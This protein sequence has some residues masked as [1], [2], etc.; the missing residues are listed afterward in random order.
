MVAGGG[1]EETATGRY[2]SV[3][4]V[5]IPGVDLER[6][7]IPSHFKLDFCSAES[8][9]SENLRTFN[10]NSANSRSFTVN[11]NF[12]TLQFRNQRVKSGNIEFGG[13]VII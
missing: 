11:F 6:S 4:T 10:R 13:V 5:A 8:I 3:P 9:K 12:K 1:G 7:V 2:G